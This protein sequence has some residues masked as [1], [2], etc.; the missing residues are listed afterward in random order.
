M[1]IFTSEGPLSI[2]PADVVGV[3]RAGGD[4]RYTFATLVL[5]R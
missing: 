4:G 2:D 3:Y 1:M 5:L